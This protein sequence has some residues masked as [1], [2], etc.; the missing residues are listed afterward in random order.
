MNLSIDGWKDVSGF[1]IYALLLLH[2]QYIKQFIDILKLNLKHY[3]AE[4]IV[5]SVKNCLDQNCVL[6]KNISAVVMDSPSVMIKFQNLLTKDKPYI[7]KTH[8]VF[9]TKA[10]DSW[11]GLPDDPQSSPLK[12]FAITISEIVPHASGIEGLFSV[13]SAVKTKYQNP[14]L[15]TTLKMISQIKLQLTQKK[16]QKSKNK[17]KNDECS[18]TSEYNCMCGYK[19]FSS[20][21]ELENLEDG[22]FDQADMQLTWHQDAL[23]E[24]MFDFDSWEQANQI[25]ATPQ[26][27]VGGDLQELCCTSS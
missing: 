23:I 17:H 12:K 9:P 25:V 11:L 18:E 16:P 1:S 5:E 24:T 13:M 14:M 15:P 8:C 26:M 20:P 27:V 21:L 2:G 4:N 3:T 19:S 22:V 7:M 6:L 10:M